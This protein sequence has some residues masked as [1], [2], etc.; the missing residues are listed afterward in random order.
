MG[1]GGSDVIEKR[2]AKR[3]VRPFFAGFGLVKPSRPAI[4]SRAIDQPHR[5]VSV[6]EMGFEEPNLSATQGVAEPDDVLQF[7]GLLDRLLV[8]GDKQSH[9]D[10]EF[11][12]GCGK[13]GRYIG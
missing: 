5:H 9:V 7:G 3:V 13:R 1:K 2:E 4:E 12:Q 8:A 11:L 6:R 10:A